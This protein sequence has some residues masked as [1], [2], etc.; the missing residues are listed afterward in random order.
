MYLSTSTVLD[1]NLGYNRHDL[2]TVEREA[3]RPNLGH[4]IV[5]YLFHDFRNIIVLVLLLYDIM[6]HIV[7][8]C[9]CLYYVLIMGF[10]PEIKSCILHIV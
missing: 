7:F 6:C 3:K 9:R 8:L 4:C 2:E 1:P 10:V 5:F